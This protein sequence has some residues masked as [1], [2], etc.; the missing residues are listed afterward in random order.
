MSAVSLHLLVYDG[1]GARVFDSFGG[2][3]LVHEV[4]VGIPGRSDPNSRPQF[5]SWEMRLKRKR[6]N[7][8]AAIREGVAMAFPPYLT[9]PPPPVAA[10]AGEEH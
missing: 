5:Q 7:D 2:L 4:D 3:D 6:L 10:P 9:P 1:T 8:T